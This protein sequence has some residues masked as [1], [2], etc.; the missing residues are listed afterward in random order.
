MDRRHRP[1]VAQQDILVSP[2]RVS[3]DIKS[4]IISFLR[5]KWRFGEH[6]IEHVFLSHQESNF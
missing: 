6:E 1:I 5:K 4:L 3:T 2:V